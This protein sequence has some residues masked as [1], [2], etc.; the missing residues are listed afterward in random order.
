[1][2]RH[3]LTGDAVEDPLRC[4]ARLVP[5]LA[6]LPLAAFAQTAPAPTAGALLNQ[7]QPPTTAAPAPAAALPEFAAPRAVAAAS[8]GGLAFEVKGFR[9]AGIDEARAAALLPALAKYTGPGRRI[10]DLEDAA[11]DVEVALQRAGLFLAQA[12]VPEQQIEAGVVAL[13]VLPGRIGSVKVET[14]PGVKVDPAFLDRIVAALRGNPVADRETVE[15]TLFTLGDLRGIT[16][17]S[18]LAPGEKPGLADLTVAVKAAPGAAYSLEYDSG[19]SVYTG[20]NRFYATG[21]WFNLAG[22]GDVASLR[23]QAASGTRFLR[24]AWLVPVNERGTRLGLAASALEYELQTA[25]FDAL[26]ARGTAAALSAQLLHPLRRSRN[27]NLFLQASVDARRFVDKVRAIDLTTKKGMTAYGTLGVVGDF[28]DTLGGGGISNYA[29]NLVAGRLRIDTADERAVDAA[30]YR[31]AGSYQKLMLNAA[32]LQVL[33]WKDYLYL[34][35]QAQ[36]ASRNLDSSEKFSMGG[37]TAVRAYPSSETP[38]DEAVVLGWE[39]RKPF[40]VEALPGDWIAS[41]FGD[42]GVARQHVDPLPTDVENTRHLHAHGLGLTYA[43]TGGLQVRGWIA[44]RGSTRAQSD[45]SRTR[46]TLQVSQQF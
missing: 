27:S 36:F 23:A 14:A 39:Y 26:D 17:E 13:Q 42:Y 20:R 4:T 19:G 41:V 44:V 24:A 38:S 16:L 22:R 29:A 12:Y 15:R 8:S 28:R 34:S 40:A 10:A 21:E 37:P 35:A 32:R 1:M 7:L 2:P 3:A 6:A 18:T 9:L 45:D 46:F 31:S 30:A 25:V 11:K 5:L 43:G 33:P